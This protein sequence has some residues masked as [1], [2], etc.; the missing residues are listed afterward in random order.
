M[1]KKVN[2][3]NV[4]EKKPRKSLVDLMTYAY[5]RRIKKWMFCP[6]CQNGKMAI[7]HSSTLWQC[8]DCGY[9]LSADEFEDDYVFWFCD[10]CE[11][12]LNMQDGFN[13]NSIKHICQ[14]CGYE[15]DTTFENIKGICSDC[16]KK[17]PD[18]D[19]TLCVDC[20]IIRKE[21]AKKWLLT[22]GVVAAGVVLAVVTSSDSESTSEPSMSASLPNADDSDNDDEVYGL[23]PGRFPTCKTC[24]ASMTQFDN[25]AWY[26]CP[27]CQ[28][29]VRIIEGKETWYDEIFGTGKKQHYSDYGLADFCR[30]G[31]LSED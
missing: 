28:D 22:A 9:Q 16:G 18:P 30:G 3:K 11:A 10:E 29:R 12:Y 13:R 5:I 4:D 26:T 23:G 1:A 17:I 6:A 14:K 21:K 25:W 2:K 15:N 20:K 31:D 8:E 24:G 19:A 7:N 27:M